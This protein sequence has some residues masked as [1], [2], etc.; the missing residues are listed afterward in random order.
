MSRVAV[1][2]GAASGMGR[3]I[4]IGLAAAGHRVA[5]LDRQGDLT[6]A[7][8]EEIA[9]AGGEAIADEVDVSDWED[10]R[11][12]LDAV[13]TQWGPITVMVTAA[14]IT[15]FTDAT[16]ISREEWDRYLAVNL[17]GTFG[18]V[19]AVIPDM[20]QAGWG[21]VVMISSCSAQT[22]SKRQAH[23]SA[24]KGGV[25]SL[26][27]TLAAELS[28]QGIT[29]NTIPPSIV[30]TPMV[31]VGVASGDF[32]GLDVIASITPVRRTGF[33]EDIAAATTFLCSDDAGFIT[34]QSI[35]VNGGLYM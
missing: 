16:A 32:P 10:V 21:R 27:K 5:L 23:Y 6:R 33:V 25:M 8:A 12:G 18:C 11:R 29:V 13:R 4:A 30:D 2:T 34:G 9:A 35:N 20:V 15:G 28:P 24:S 7:A 22:G 14:G 26:T 3:G 1:V 19:Q 17:S 31:Q